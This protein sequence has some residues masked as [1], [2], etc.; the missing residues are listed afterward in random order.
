[1]HLLL[2]YLLTYPG[3]YLFVCRSLGL[4]RGSDNQSLL[5]QSLLLIHWSLHCCLVKRFPSSSESTMRAIAHQVGRGRA[6]RHVDCSCLWRDWNTYD[7][8]AKQQKC[9]SILHRVGWRTTTSTAPTTYFMW[10][11]RLGRP[12]PFVAT[13]Y[14]PP[15]TMYLVCLRA[16]PR[17]DDITA[18]YST[19]NDRDHQN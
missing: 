9:Q 16:V 7:Y 14:D 13:V 2:T 4:S 1:M 17:P 18:N 15:L 8:V 11:S 5:R 6:Q 12:F 10:T 3:T 19:Y